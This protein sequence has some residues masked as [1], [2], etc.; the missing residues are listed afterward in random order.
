[1]A[2]NIFECQGPM[3][4][5]VIQQIDDVLDKTGVTGEEIGNLEQNFK[6]SGMCI[7]ETH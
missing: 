5:K 7:K 3:A 2:K 6:C 4:K 1:M